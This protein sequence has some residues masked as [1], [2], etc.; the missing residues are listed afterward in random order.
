MSENCCSQPSAGSAV[1]ELP[2][3]TVQRKSH[4]EAFCPECK[5]KGKVVQGQTVKA[6]VAV[7][8]C[9]IQETEYYFCRT[10]SCPVVYYSADGKSTFTTS[11][12]RERVYQKEPSADEVLV[13]YC[14]KHTVAD[15]RNASAE[16]GDSILKDIN[17][18]IQTNQCACDLRNPQGSCCLGNVR[19]LLKQKEQVSVQ[20]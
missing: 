1:C 3:V 19:G 6:L 13:C 18:G 8:L 17:T 9:S 14:F 4:L 11:Q 20:P 2:S 7:S 16:Y 5:Q 15:I 12:L 10:Q